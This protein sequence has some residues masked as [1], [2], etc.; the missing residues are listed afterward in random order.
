M[1]R[2]GWVLYDATCGICNRWVPFWRRTLAEIGLDVAPLQ[3]AWVRER[4]GM[5][6]EALL[7]DVRVLLEDGTLYTGAEAYLYCMKRLWWAWPLYVLF[8][9]P[10]LSWLFRACYR[11]FATHRHAISRACRLAPMQRCANAS[12]ARPLQPR[13]KQ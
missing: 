3:A 7:R 13:S 5:A 1:T 12:G 8:T 10:L 4:T 2:I 11:M 9:L 6:S